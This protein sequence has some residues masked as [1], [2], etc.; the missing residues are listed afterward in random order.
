[1]NRVI[2]QISVMSSYKT[3]VAFLSSKV[4]GERR[5]GGGDRLSGVAKESILINQHKNDYEKES[6]M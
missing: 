4:E 2:E 5:E 6:Y 3:A 1:M